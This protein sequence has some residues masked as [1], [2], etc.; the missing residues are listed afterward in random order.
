MIGIWPV[1]IFRIFE[2]IDRIFIVIILSNA[3][4]KLARKHFK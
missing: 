2:E 1:F 3:N 4:S